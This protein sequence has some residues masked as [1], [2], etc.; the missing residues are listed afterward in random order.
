M[1]ALRPHHFTDLPRDFIAKPFKDLDL[2]VSRGAVP[3][4]SL[5]IPVENDLRHVHE[6]ESA[7]IGIV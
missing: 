4:L 2:G 1:D 5:R 6:S 7:R 3:L